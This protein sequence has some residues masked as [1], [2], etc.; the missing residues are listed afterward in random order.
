MHAAV[1]KRESSAS[2]VAAAAMRRIHGNCCCC[3][4]P[5]GERYQPVVKNE[6]DLT[7]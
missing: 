6:D 4:R 7:A 1:R 5:K 2:N 3:I